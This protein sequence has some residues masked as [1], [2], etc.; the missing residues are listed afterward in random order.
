MVFPDPALG[1][2]GS[3]LDE[4]ATPVTGRSDF[5]E[6]SSLS[7]GGPRV[8]DPSHENGR[9]A[10]SSGGEFRTGNHWTRH[11]WLVGIFLRF[12]ER[13][14]KL[15]PFS[16]RFVGA[17]GSQ[18]PTPCHDSIGNPLVRHRRISEALP[19]C[20]CCFFSILYQYPPWHSISRSEAN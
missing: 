17:N 3:S 1:S 16:F 20:E 15:G 7:A 19:H 2:A 5:P 12:A 13:I 8:G 4:L 10:A 11:R 14:I 18:R 9:V 6:G